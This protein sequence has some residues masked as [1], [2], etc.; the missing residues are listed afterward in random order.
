M[1]SSCHNVAQDYSECCETS[2]GKPK[3]G[4][5]HHDNRSFCLAFSRVQLVLVLHQTG[6]ERERLCEAENCLCDCVQPVDVQY[7]LLDYRACFVCDRTGEIRQ[8]EPDDAHKSDVA[9]Y[10]G[11][12][13][14]EMTLDALEFWQHPPQKIADN[15]N[16]QDAQIPPRVVYFG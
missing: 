2:Q 4:G 13:Q 16:C 6:R 8:N 15:V 12:L 14:R 5:R 7:W 3:L 9:G 10:V 1:H 11:D